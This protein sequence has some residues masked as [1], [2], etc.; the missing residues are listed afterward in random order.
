MD[1]I[2][3][4]SRGSLNENDSLD[5]SFNSSCTSSP[6]PANMSPCLVVSSQSSGGY[7]SSVGRGSPVE[8]GRVPKVVPKA[9]MHPYNRSPAC[10]VPSKDLPASRKGGERDGT[11]ANFS[12]ELEETSSN[13]LELLMK[14]ACRVRRREIVNA[15]VE[16]HRAKRRESEQQ[17][18]E[19]VEHLE[20]QLLELKMEIQS[21]DSSYVFAPFQ[22]PEQPHEALN[23]SSRKPREPQPKSDEERRERKRASGRIS[24]K[25]ATLKKKYEALC[26][27]EYIPYL[28]SQ[29]ELANK[30]LDQHLEHRKDID[31]EDKSC[32]KKSS[33]TSLLLE[34]AQTAISLDRDFFLEKSRDDDKKRQI[35]KSSSV[36]DMLPHG[37]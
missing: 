33:S 1:I 2:E 10:Q 26:R 28:R 19:T 30:W 34:L 29:I 31:I 11:F 8:T 13:A 37:L 27:K 20:K 12:R 25:K 32:F 4:E 9:R 16:K 6:V 17:E 35:I 3:Q 5:G 23:N 14:I 24:Q 7:F 18:K 36:N 15:S 21:I 22:A